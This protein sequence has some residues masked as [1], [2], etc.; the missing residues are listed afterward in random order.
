MSE[1]DLSPKGLK[2]RTRFAREDVGLCPF[3]GSTVKECNL[4]TRSFCSIGFLRN[5]L[6]SENTQWNYAPFNF[7]LNYLV[8]E[9][10]EF[11]V[12]SSLALDN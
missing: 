3:Y 2:N 8:H 10:M 1:Y 4:F 6:L 9:I 12:T 7:T 5:H 11:C